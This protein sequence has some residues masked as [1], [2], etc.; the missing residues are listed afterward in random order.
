MYHQSKLPRVV[1]FAFLIFGLI[2]SA[3]NLSSGSGNDAGLTVTAAMNNLTETAKAAPTNTVVP[4]QPEIPVPPPA[5]ATIPVE[6]PIAT[7]APAVQGPTLTAL[8]NTNCRMGADP[9]YPVTGAFIKNMEVKI[10]GTNENGSWWLIEDP[11][12]AGQNCWVWGQT[13]QVNGD[14][15]GVPFIPSPAL[16]ADIQVP[17]PY[18]LP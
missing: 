16:P 14:T 6:A 4:T 9:I 8:D 3:C 13:T 5:Q 1:I 18:P 11:A 7:E 15:S 17:Y 10:I 2:S 12:K